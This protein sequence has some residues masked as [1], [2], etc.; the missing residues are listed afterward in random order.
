MIFSLFVSADSRLKYRFLFHEARAVLELPGLARFQTIHVWDTAYRHFAETSPLLS[1]DT[2]DCRQLHRILSIRTA[3]RG[4][5]PVSGRKRSRRAAR[6]L[7]RV[8]G[9]WVCAVN[10]YRRFEAV[11]LSRPA[12]WTED[13]GISV[14]HLPDGT[15]QLQSDTRLLQNRVLILFAISKNTVR[16]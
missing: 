2:A 9:R 7:Q 6:A 15:G 16:R 5:T 11:L 4:N 13:T 8:P 3:F 14:G 12:T 1:D 10:H